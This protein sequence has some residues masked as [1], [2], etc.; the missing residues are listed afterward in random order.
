ML[1]MLFIKFVSA[2]LIGLILTLMITTFYFMNSNYTVKVILK[3]MLI[4]FLSISIPCYIIFE[5]LI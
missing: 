5:L 2:I 4:T 1:N 3:K